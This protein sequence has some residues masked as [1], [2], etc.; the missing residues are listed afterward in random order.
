[1]SNRDRSRGHRGFAPQNRVR[2]PVLN[3]HPDRNGAA[4]TAVVSDPKLTCCSIN[5]RTVKVWLIDTG[6]TLPSHWFATL[7]SHRLTAKFPLCGPTPIGVRGLGSYPFVYQAIG[8]SLTVQPERAVSPRETSRT[9]PSPNVPFSKPPLMICAAAGDAL[10]STH[11]A[12]MDW[13][14]RFM[15]SPNTR[16]HENVNRPGI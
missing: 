11:A 5:G 1:M 15:A 2:C 13:T 9:L 3:R 4:V 12:I 14:A 7:P 10:A 8:L 16:D 6:R